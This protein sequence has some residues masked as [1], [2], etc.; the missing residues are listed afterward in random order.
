M[1][2]WMDGLIVSIMVFKK[3]YI[4][5]PVLYQKFVLSTY[6]LFYKINYL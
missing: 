5:E 2:E 1:A 3:K 6:L 4:S